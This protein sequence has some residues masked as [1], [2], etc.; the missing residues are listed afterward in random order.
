MDLLSI[1]L[2][3][4]ALW[5]AI[6]IV[7]LALARAAGRADGEADHLAAHGEPTR[8]SLTERSPLDALADE[9]MRANA[10][11]GAG[12]EDVPEQPVRDRRARAKRLRKRSRLTANA[13]RIKNSLH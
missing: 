5:I 12:A 6:I 2:V 10:T 7:C 13:E 8:E 1:A 11:T 9:V 3:L 4:I